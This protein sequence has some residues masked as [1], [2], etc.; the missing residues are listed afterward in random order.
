VILSRLTYSQFVLRLVTLFMPSAAFAVAGYIRFSIPLRSSPPGDVDP[1]P[2]FGLLLFS[3]VVWAIAVDQFH[4]FDVEGLFTSGG[5]TRR[6]F[7]ACGVTYASIMTATFF[8][9]GIS[10]SRLFVLLGGVALFLLTGLM[11]LIFRIALDSTSQNGN[12]VRLLII[13]ADR[14]ADQAARSLLAGQVMPCRLVGFVRL[15]GQQ[16]EVTS[17]QVFELDEIK[18]LAATTGIDDAVISLPLSRWSEIPALLSSLEY[19]CVPI[20]A[21]LDLGEGVR[22]RD[23]LCDLGGVM[24]LDIRTTPAES[25]PYLI[26]KRVFDIGFSISVLIVTA[27]LMVLIAL[28]IRLS[29]PGPM[30]FVQDRV[31][32][33]GRRFKIYKFRTMRVEDRME[34]DTRWTTRNDPRRTAFGK[35]LRRTNLDELPQFINVFRGDMSVV[36]PRPERPHFVQEFLKH[37]ANYN[38]RHYLKAGITGWAQVNGLRGDTSISKRLEYDLYYLEHWSFTFDLQIV[39]L[40]IRRIFSSEQ[41]Y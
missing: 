30:L 13:G 33:N 8:Y 34:S 40:T 11:R 21:I 1:A 27:P 18:H 31:G 4:L 9:R 17:G 2:Y 25:V 39:L 24:M 36:G 5:K 38:S 23:K 35:F 12:R 3:T 32:L 29:S 7:S 15:P 14:Y 37:Y 20:R 28:T 22:V 10:F 6:L 16:A 26:V 41:A 19:L